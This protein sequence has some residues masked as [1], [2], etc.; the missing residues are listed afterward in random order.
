[1]NFL[2][3]D[4]R[5]YIENSQRAARGGVPYSGPQPG[6]FEAMI[7]LAQLAE[8]ITRPVSLEITQTDSTIRVNREENFALICN[9][10][11]NNNAVS[12]GTY[13]TEQCGWNAD[14]MIFYTILPDSLTILH[15]LTLSPDAQ[16][17]NIITTLNSSYATVPFS[18]SHF[19]HRYE[20]TPSQFDCTLTLTRNQVC[21]RVSH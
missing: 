15:R 3:L 5:R 18:L 8:E 12:I 21:T 4:M 7:G 10:R 6:S 11:A 20:K 1:M 17:L 9:F 13:G 14:R 19:Y 16:E 2:F